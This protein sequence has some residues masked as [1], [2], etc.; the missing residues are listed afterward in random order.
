MKPDLPA[1]NGYHDHV[2][3]EVAPYLKPHSRILEIGC[4]SGATL[5]FLKQQG[6]CDWAGGAEFVAAAAQK[7]RQVADKVWIGDVESMEFDIEEGSLDAVLCLDVLE[8]LVDPWTM[9]RRMASLLAPGGLLLVSLPNI[10][11]Y[12]ILGDLVLRGRWEYRD[13]GILDRTH[14]RFFTRKSA[15]ALV[16]GAG[17]T[18]ETVQPLGRMKPW[19]L[20]WVVNRLTGGRMMEFY[21]PQFLV[22]GRK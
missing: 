22:C 11:D 2:R 14:L 12:H 3:R 19:R 18:V 9:A 4:G 13:S 21:A 17:L 16:A 7:A 15:V 1:E 6:L 20:K 8:H 5:G 10:R